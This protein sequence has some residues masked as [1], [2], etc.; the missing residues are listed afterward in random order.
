VARVKKWGEKIK[1]LDVA[2]LSGGGFEKIKW[3]A[4]ESPI[5]FFNLER[6]GK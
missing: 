6:V 5:V 3:L 2:K 4:T 1:W